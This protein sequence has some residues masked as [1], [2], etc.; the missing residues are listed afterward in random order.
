MRMLGS[1]EFREIYE[2]SGIST[3]FKDYV[4]RMALLITATFVLTTVASM[5]IHSLLL[6]MVGLS[7]LQAV[8][9][10]SLAASGLLAFALLYYP[11]HQRN[12]RRGKTDDGLVYA[13]SYMTVLSAGGISIERIMERVSETEES[14]PLKQLAKKFMMDIRLFG[15]DVTSALRDISR[16]SPSKILSKLLDSVINTVQTSG[17]L[18]SLLT[19]EVEGLLQ[20]KREKLK[21]MMGTL[22]YMGEMYVTLMVVAPILFIL[23]LTILSVLGGRAGG[24]SSILQLNLLVFFGVPVMAAGFIIILDTVIRGEE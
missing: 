16:R 13:L 12:Q 23:M 17:D 1:R 24:A 6:R 10:P 18:K 4:R 19:Y 8:F 21:K 14:T 3:S 7:L 20:R 11:Y 5:A 22:T 2:E 9:S 15:L